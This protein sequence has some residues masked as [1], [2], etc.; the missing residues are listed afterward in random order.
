M[1]LEKTDV[2]FMYS[3]CRVIQICLNIDNT[4]SHVELFRKHCMLYVHL[5]I[6]EISAGILQ[7]IYPTTNPK[8]RSD[9][10][11]F[12]HVLHAVAS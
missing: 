2:L 9:T 6:D 8:N 11:G 12:K 5:T 10:H 4:I 3:I 7:E 1:V